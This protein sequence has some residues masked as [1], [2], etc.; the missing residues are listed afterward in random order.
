MKW[1]M[2]LIR[3]AGLGAAAVML[4]GI[5]AAAPASSPVFFLPSHNQPG[6]PAQFVVRGS[7]LTAFFAPGTV[8]FR[9]REGAVLMQFAGASSSARIEPLEQ[10]PGMANILEGSEENWQVGLPLYRGVAYRELYPGI[11]LTYGSSG[12]RLK[13]Q[14]VVAPGADPSR[15]LIRYSGAGQLQLDSDGSLIVPVGRRQVREEA[16][17]AW[18]EQNGLRVPVNIQF[19]LFGDAVG[20]AAGSYDRTA[21]LVI[22]PTVSYSTLLGGS[23]VN[24]GMALAVDPTGA[25]YIAGFTSSYNFPT[26]N[27]EQNFN[28]G[29]NDVFVAKLNPA[30]NALVYATYIGGSGDDRAYGIA[31]D[32]T[33]AAYVAGS[34]QSA[35]FPVRNALQPRLAGGRNAFVLKLSPAG[36]SLVF[37]TYLGGSG[38]DVANGVAVDSSANIYIAGDTTSTNFPATSAAYQRSNRGSQNAFV[39]KLNSNC[40]SLIY[41]TYIGGSLTDHAAGIAVD[42]AGTAFIAGSTWSTNFPVANAYQSTLAGGQDAFVA[43]IAASG[44][45]L[46]FSTYLGGSGGTVGQ[47][48]TA[49]GIALDAQG[50]AY[51]TGTTSSSNFPLLN[52]YQST[53]RGWSDAFIS[54]F[55]SAGALV[56]STYL[57]GSGLDTANGIA[58]DASGNAYIAGYTNVMDMVTATASASPG[59]YNAFVA[60][61]NSAG[62]GLPAY[63]YIVDTGSDTAS[64][65]ALDYSGNIYFAGWTLSPNFPVLNGMQSVNGG[66]S[67]FVSKISFST[68][69]PRVVSVTPSSGSG[70]SQVFAFQ[71]SD[72]AG[73]ADLT[74][75]S[76]LIGS[77]LSLSNA[78]AVTYN[79]SAGTL[80]LLT[81][82]GGIPGQKVALGAGTQQNSQC[83]LDGTGSSASS[84]GNT[85]MLNLALAFKSAFAGAKAVYGQATNSSTTTGWQQVGSWSVSSGSIAFGPVSVN[86]GSGS[87]SSQTFTLT[88]SDPGGYAAIVSTATV[89]GS[90]LSASGACYIYFSRSANT[91]YLA[92][93]SGGQ[94]LGPLAL[95]Q[96]GSLQNS[97]CSISGSNSSSSGNG[98]RLALSLAISFQPGFSGAKN[99]YMD[100]YDGVDS[101]WQLKG[102]WTVTTSGTSGSGGG[103]G[104]GTPPPF[105]P[106][107]VSPSSGTGDTQTFALT[108]SDPAGYAAIA[109]TSTVFGNALSASNSCYTYLARSTNAVYLA[110]DAGNQWLGP[111]I[112]G[113]N[114][115]LQ[116]SQCSIAGVGSSSSGSGYTLTL[117]LAVTF[118]TSGA[119]NIFMEV[120]DGTDSGWQQ[121]GTWTAP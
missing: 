47:P 2:F 105:G 106:G 3:T 18:Q 91:V 88:Y 25:A 75:I 26:A 37:S 96:N 14:F 78:C 119:K 16:P 89:I 36:N 116:N 103:G 81:D 23:G 99:T 45:S 101:G 55:S 82:T 67:A 113:Q 21:P 53:L 57:G 43:R 66:Y 19:A 6:S 114:G 28:S 120:Y 8:A 11:D 121:K 10:L 92:N 85:L 27:P 83:I 65:I 17:V 71:F 9:T 115:S 107:A 77:G 15:I 104:S 109:S 51:V 49:N 58:V 70:S 100:V 68:P 64:A 63:A 73:A 20:F 5:S 90:G 72:G 95:G 29:G 108:Y 117:N 48:E 97:Q 42:A 61:L 110:N 7:G 34:T 60:E 12:N 98:F 41:A 30:G 118:K 38:L 13:S 86:P 79:P 40:S 94:W 93:D 22:D 33:G 31:V 87:G 35:N 102:T 80:A 76:V 1:V 52:P 54:K 39:A 74:A 112:L 46:L 59:A 4:A 84:S 111:V 50:S 44:A 62:N 24:A 56:Y 69:V 32:S